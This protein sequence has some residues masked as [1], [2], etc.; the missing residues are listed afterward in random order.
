MRL[1]FRY[2]FIISVL[3]ITCTAPIKAQEFDAT[4]AADVMVVSP[5]PSYTLPYPG[6]LPD[7][8]LYGLK[9][10]RDKIIEF[11]ISDPIK[12]IEFNL[13]QAD[14]RLNAGIYLSNQEKWEL[15]Q[16]TVSK[17][18][19]YF[20]IAIGKTYEAQKQGIDTKSLQERMSFS[21][22]KHKQMILFLEGK[23]PNN[24]KDKFNILKKRIDVIENKLSLL[25][26]NKK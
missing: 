4:Q 16:E 13:L 15:A 12:R 21:K 22:E 24:Q 6:L 18:E 10:I 11:I 26:E 2:F 20:E 25:Q 19:N 7:S 23:A 1:L 5:T 17:A 3:F 9:M 14:K 8:P